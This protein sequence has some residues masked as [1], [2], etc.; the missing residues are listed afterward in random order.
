MGQN[1]STHL[2]Q[3][4]FTHYLE[5]RLLGFNAEGAIAS[6]R[7]KCRRID[8]GFEYPRW[9]NSI[10]WREQIEVAQHDQTRG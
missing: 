4:V 6:D 5:N 7:S 2:R 10:A 8:S 1:R 9:T 3:S